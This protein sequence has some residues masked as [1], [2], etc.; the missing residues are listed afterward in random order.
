MGWVETLAQTFAQY[1]N[2]E[3][4]RLIAGY[5]ADFNKVARNDY[6]PAWLAANTHHYEALA[7]LKTFE[8]DTDELATKTLISFIKY[9]R[10]NF[11]QLR[12]L[13]DAGADVNVELWDGWETFSTSCFAQYG[14]LEGLRLIA[15]Y[16]ADFNKVAGNTH[17]PAWL[18]ANTHKR[19]LLAFLKA[20]G[21]K[22]TW[23]E[24]LKDYSWLVGALVS[25]I[26]YLYF[27]FQACPERDEDFLHKVE[28]GIQERD[29]DFLKK[30]EEGIKELDEDFFP[31]SSYKLADEDFFH[32]VLW[33][34]QNWN[35]CFMEYAESKRSQVVEI[36]M[37]QKKISKNAQDR[38]KKLFSEEAQYRQWLLNAMGRLSQT[39]KLENS[40]K[41][42][43]RWFNAF[44]FETDYIENQKKEAGDKQFLGPITL[45]KLRKPVMA[46]DGFVYELETIEEL[47]AQSDDYPWFKSPMTNENI[48]FVFPCKK[49]KLEILKMQLLQYKELFADIANTKRKR[50]LI[51]GHY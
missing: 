36:V 13:L 5:G 45:E 30:V 51:R 21:A 46:E 44:P 18:A 4:L 2:L 14:N 22:E 43:L 39:R 31:Q 9:T 49:I 3:G 20:H 37:K 40:Y 12:H 15:G 11:N 32:K 26:S 34:I 1:G 6:S 28:R 25:G 50:K 33:F 19:E 35:W 47:K 29:E 16:G 10:L 48:D 38:E 17:S 27:G 41:R 23:T 42:S 7:L 24:F 8:V